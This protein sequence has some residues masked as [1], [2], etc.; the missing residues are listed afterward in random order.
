MPPNPRAAFDIIKSGQLSGSIITV[1]DGA[2]A[3][4]CLVYPDVVERL[5]WSFPDPSSLQAHMKKIS[6]YTKNT[7]SNKR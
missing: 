6:S 2:S 5:H 1:C 3:E 4:H 7:R